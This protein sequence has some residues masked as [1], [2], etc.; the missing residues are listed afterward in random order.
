MK[1]HENFKQKNLLKNNNQNLCEIFAKIDDDK[2]TSLFK[3]LMR[4]NNMHSVKI[5][6]IKEI[7]NDMLHI[8][9]ILRKKI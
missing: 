4:R 2:N 1:T 8:L 6:D 9:I 3:K 7:Q 5:Y